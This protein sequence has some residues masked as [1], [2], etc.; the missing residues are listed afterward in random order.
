MARIEIG[1]LGEVGKMVTLPYISKQTI[2][3]I[4][5][6][7]LLFVETSPIAAHVG[8]VVYALDEL[9]KPARTR[10]VNTF[11]EMRD[12][13]VTYIGPNLFD[14]IVGSVFTT[15]GLRLTKSKKEEPNGLQQKP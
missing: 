8:G 7:A 13:A 10:A 5:E 11:A 9:R 6:H 4:G 3:N 14:F 15:A 12:A 2:L 1:P